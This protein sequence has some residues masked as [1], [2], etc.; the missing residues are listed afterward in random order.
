MM[1]SLLY[2]DLGWKS[3]NLRDFGDETK[4]YDPNQLYNLEVPIEEPNSIKS[5]NIYIALGNR[6]QG[7]TDDKFNDCL[8]NCLKYY[9]FNVE[10]YFKSPAELKKYLGLGR[11]D[12]VPLAAIEKIEKKLK[13]YQINV[14]GEFIRIS[15]VKS[16]KQI[17]LTLSN[18]HFSVEKPNRIFTP[19][20]RFEEKQPLLY[21]K[22]TFEV[23]D[24]Q[25]KWT[26][27]KQE[28][29]KL[30]YDFSGKYILIDRLGFDRD[31]L[32]NK[33]VMT[34]EEEYKEFIE[35]ADTLKHESKG[36]INL[37]KSG[38]YHDTALSLFDRVSKY[39]NPE[40]ILQDEAEWIK[41]SS[42][43][44]LIWCEPYTGEL[45]K[46]DVKSMYPYLMSSTTLKFPVKRGE[47]KL[48]DNF[49]TEYFDYGIYRC[50]ILKS[51]DPNVSKLFKCN[52]HNFY[53]SIDLTNAKQL[54]L[55]IE[56]IKDGKPNFLY[57]SREK[58]ITF[59]E[60]FKTYI[61]ILFP[62]KDK[63][64]NKAKYILNMLWGALCEVD[65]R[66]QY[67]KD[68]F[69][70][71]ED[72]EICEIYPSNSEDD[73]HVI[74]TT[75]SNGYYK[76]SFAR[77]CPFIISQGR[78]Q[79]TNLMLPY[80]DSIHRIQTDGFLTSKPIHILTDVKLGELKYEGYT[81]TG[82]ITNCINRV[83]VH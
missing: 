2:G 53:T 30:L 13:T 57:W 80:K 29:N 8:Y 20:V 77:L 69:R 19:L 26:I 52:Y 54:G 12:K 75:K 28:R 70:I 11:Y 51:E 50:K 35:I 82:I 24:G 62:L 79:M 17:N 46:Y 40:P 33:R 61:D 44:A 31:E 68:S 6:A 74:K 58:T 38:N 67:I 9:I 10:E 76:T 81:E 43:S 60:V 7:G 25:T 3:G 27:T 59:N 56:L 22:K 15:T 42:F 23:F 47:F 32:D 83:E 5:F 63:K 36:M 14:R 65:K 21:D 73:A 37:Y 1:T 78:R 66:K 55:E 49:N 64:V 45:Y 48:I 4:L 16:N 72:E 71:E 18:E 41:L 34:I 39:I